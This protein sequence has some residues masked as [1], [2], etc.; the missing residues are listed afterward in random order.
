M[1]DLLKI[2]NLKL[3][4]SEGTAIIKL[5]TCLRLKTKKQALK[6]LKNGADHLTKLP[7]HTKTR[8]LLAKI[9]RQDSVAE[10]LMRQEFLCCTENL[11]LDP[12]AWHNKYT[13]KRRHDFL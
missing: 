5:D 3:F 11:R 8:A 6:M 1:Y 9:S 10:L 4:Y 2:F 7:E 12:K 13:L